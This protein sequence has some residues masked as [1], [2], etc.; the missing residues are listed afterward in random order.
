MQCVLVMFQVPG[1][2]LGAVRACSPE[3]ISRA[4]C[5]GDFEWDWEII[6]F[7]ILL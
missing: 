1:F 4:F 7:K 6:V 2:C 3:I 5:P